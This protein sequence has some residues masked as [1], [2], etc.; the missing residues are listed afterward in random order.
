MRLF[1]I[2]V[3]LDKHTLRV[4]Y[5]RPTFLF[6][7]PFLRYLDATLSAAWHGRQSMTLDEMGAALAVRD[8]LLFGVGCIELLFGPDSDDEARE[9]LEAHPE[10]LHYKEDSD[11]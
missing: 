2:N 4:F 11:D 8:C 6:H 3:D 7:L 10:I 9:A 1:I 5:T